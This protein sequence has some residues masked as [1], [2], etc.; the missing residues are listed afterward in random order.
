MT[1][2]RFIPYILIL[3]ILLLATGVRF[4]NLG[5]QS[6]WYDEGVAFG[7][8][9]RTLGEMIPRLQ[10]NV[11]VPAYF[12]SLSL[13]ENFVGSTEFGLRSYSVLWS[14][15]SIAAVYAIGKRLFHPIVGL[16][17]ALIVALNSFSIY[18]AQ[19]TRMYA[20]LAAIGGLSIWAFVQWGL[21]A[22]KTTSI[23][24]NKF[25]FRR[26]WQ[27]GIAFAVL[28]IIGEYTHVS[29]ALVMLTQGLLA[30]FIIGNLLS[31]AFQQTISQK[32]VWQIIGIYVAVNVLTILFFA[33]WLIVAVSQ[34][35]SQPNISEPLS[36]AA[37]I[38]IIQGWFAFGIT[39]EVGM[40]GME[41]V[42]YFLILFGL[43]R[44]SN[45]DRQSAWWTL[46]VPIVWVL[47]ST[48]LYIYLE[49]YGR[50]LRFL[51]PAQL[52]Y[53][54]W[55]GR[56]VWVLWEIVPRNL[57]NRTGWQRQ[58]TQ[59][60]PKVAATVAI[61]AFAWQQ[62]LLLDPLYN[63][64]EYLRD[65]YR[66]MVATIEAEARSDDAI[67]LSAPGIQEI[68]GYYYD[69]DLPVY[70][71]PASD[72]IALDTA[73]I[74]N[75]HTRIYAVLYGQEEQDPE[76]IVSDTLNTV[77]F[78]IGGE[79]VGDVRFERFATPATFPTTD[80]VNITFGETITLET[81][82]LNRQVFSPNDALQVQLTWLTSAPLAT[83]Y[84]IFLQ[85]LD[86]D[87]V[88]VTQR[89]SEPAG[90]QAPTTTWQVNEPIIDNHAIA[91]PDLAE[92][93]YT[94]ILG[95]YDSNN[96]QDRLPVAEGDFYEL[97][98]ITIE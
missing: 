74:V 45:D 9:Q 63:D 35:S 49:L 19:E 55:M 71:L 85:L 4:Y 82:A 96:P 38:R 79:W 81:I 39:F 23:T 12:G 68:F 70:T 16:S 50:Y 95:L 73:T 24:N 78:P 66:T 34:I 52:G 46:A 90:N 44:L 89:D 42:V 97:A 5:T 28:N 76:G 8:S 32:V 53:A 61:L 57:E 31:K 75:D 3:C 22:L 86:S 84:K 77:G 29:Y 62:W 20:M 69:G 59:H 91:I 94:L 13:Y 58:V 25:H 30:L 54:L 65:D 41:I 98:I 37:I 56:G 7:H 21:L 83:R 47:V 26:L 14:L 6:L 51:L 87:G 1:T 72:D 18:Y 92:G 88:L 11:H 80:T 64:P 27:W 17:A 67:I 2:K 93:D 15:I 33:P 43:L 40:G 60:L 10:N 36:I 48:S